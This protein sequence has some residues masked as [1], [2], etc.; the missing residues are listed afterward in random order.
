MCIVTQ[1]HCVNQANQLHVQILKLF[2]ASAF[3]SYVYLF[4][5][6]FWIWK[7]RGPFGQNGRP[8]THERKNCFYN[9]PFPKHPSSGYLRRLNCFYLTTFEVTFGH[10]WKRT[11]RMLCCFCVWIGVPEIQAFDVR[12]FLVIICRL[13]GNFWDMA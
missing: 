6:P 9:F 2:I 12:F 10:F 3:C 7:C 11:F 8:W 1:S 5:F 4:K 13:F